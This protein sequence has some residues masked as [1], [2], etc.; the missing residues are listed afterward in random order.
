MSKQLD[1]VDEVDGMITASRAIDRTQSILEAIFGILNSDI[2]NSA[3]GFTRSIHFTAISVLLCDITIQ[4]GWTKEELFE[5]LDRIFA[6]R[7]REYHE[8]NH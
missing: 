3:D 8:S 1:D 5:R 6:D 2:D 4:T 7:E